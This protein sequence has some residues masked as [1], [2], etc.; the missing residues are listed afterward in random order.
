MINNAGVFPGAARK[1]TKDGFEM[2]MGVNHLGHFY[3][4]YLLWPSIRKAH[5]PRIINV[6]S[7][8]HRGF[9]LKKY[10][11]P[12]PS[13]DFSDFQQRNDYRP[14][15]SYSRSK[16]AN[17][18]FTKMLQKKIDDANIQA[19]SYSLHP[20]VVFTELI[21]GQGGIAGKLLF[22]LLRPLVYL[23]L[24]T[25]AEGAQTTMHLVLQN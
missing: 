8:A 1:E 23:F 11:G 3:L 18:L 6:A 17:V 16:L 21:S 7:E 9:F 4:T 22:F 19:Y 24:K 5:K 25:P 13:I 15:L 10:F 20:G 12:S 14:D 2:A